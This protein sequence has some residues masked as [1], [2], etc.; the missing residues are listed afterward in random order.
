M[1]GLREET[2]LV[3]DRITSAALADS[4]MSRVMLSR[5]SRY[6]FSRS[7]SLRGCQSNRISSN[8]WK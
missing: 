5:L 1:G 6:S 8:T 3:L 7:L 2:L 4:R